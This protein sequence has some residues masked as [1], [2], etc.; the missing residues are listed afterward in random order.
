MHWFFYNFT[1]HYPYLSSLIKFA[2]LG[3]IGEYLGAVIASK[4]NWKPF[5]ILQLIYKILIW[6][7]LGLIIKWS[8]LTFSLLIPLQSISGL[9][10]KTCSVNGSIYFA[11]AISL[12]MNLMFAPFLMILH[13]I[14]D[15]LSLKQWNF[16]GI[17]TALLSILWFWIPAHIITFVL[18]VNFRIFFAALLGIVLGIILGYSKKNK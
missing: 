18:P 13:R 8:F 16:K 2:I 17:E 14:L 7:L 10:P 12:E 9:L 5:N 4:G 11:I 1:P 3:T 15:N 6:A